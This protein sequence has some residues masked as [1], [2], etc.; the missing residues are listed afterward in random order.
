MSKDNKLLKEI[1]ENVYK[2]NKKY[3]G[4]MDSFFTLSTDDVQKLPLNNVSLK[5]PL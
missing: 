4:D 3:S 5:K 1:Y 2:G